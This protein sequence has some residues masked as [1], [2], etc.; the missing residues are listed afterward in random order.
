MLLFP[1]KKRNLYPSNGKRQLEPMA[2]KFIVLQVKTGHTKKSKRSKL[3]ILSKS[4]LH[5]QIAD[6]V[7]SSGDGGKNIEFLHS[8]YT[9]KILFFTFCH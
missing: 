5:L 9:V 6:L 2:T 8:F 1:T 3:L 4:L 7:I